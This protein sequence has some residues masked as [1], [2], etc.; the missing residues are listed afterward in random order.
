[1]PA[2]R[3][4]TSP[5]GPY[6]F[7][8]ADATLSKLIQLLGMAGSPPLR[9]AAVR[10][11]GSLGTA[12]ERALVKALLA[13]LQETDLD[14]RLGALEALGQ[15]GAEEALTTLE[16]VVRLGGPDLEAAVQ[17]A[18]QLGA[19]G[20]RAMSKIMAQA[21]PALRWRIAAV[22]A[23]SGTG[24]GLVA[25]A[26][27][28]LDA[29]AKV[30]DAAARSLAAEVP[31]FTSPQKQ[32]LAKFLSESLGAKDSLSPKTEAAM[33]RLLGTLHDAKAGD[34]FWARVGPGN[35]PEVRAAALQ[36]LGNQAVGTKAP[37]VTDAGLQRL[38]ECAAAAD[39][40]IVAPALML[41][42]NVPA[43]SKNAKLWLK[44][45]EAPDVATRRFA[46]DKLNRVETADVARGLLLQLGHADRALREEV[47]RPC[48]VSR[49]VARPFSIS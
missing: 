48:S 18:G 38:V 5:V 6:N 36:A 45:L 40:Q 16:S 41:L 12:K 13:V 2:L 24:G 17:A 3:R 4:A 9:L 37:P 23:K 21:T 42:K 35:G 44:L 20:I 28:L 30:V 11:S 29:D 34:L 33:I 10:V 26:H 8:M 14:L 22:L 19:R 49:K 47:R 1:M 25:T 31:G 27:A 46:V 15:L 39:F 43:S 7:R 32:A